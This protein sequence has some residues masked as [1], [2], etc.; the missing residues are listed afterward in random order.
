[1]HDGRFAD[2]ENPED[3]SAL[4]QVVAFYNN[5][6]EF[7]SNLDPRLKDTTGTAARRLNWS[8]E[9]IAAV[10]AYLRTQT[11]YV[12]LTSPLF[13]DPFVTLPG[14]YTGDGIVDDNDFNLST[15]EYGDV[16]SLQAD[17]NSDLVV[18]AADYVLWRKFVGLTWLDLAIPPNPGS[19]GGVPEPSGVAL[20]AILF[21]WRIA[22][23]RP[24]SSRY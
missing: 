16:T 5:G 19:S 7:S 6:V 13:A 4:E 24:R 22:D 20:A 3:P 12:F 9:N 21:G 23:R 14:D 1:M 15:A 18:D 17:G 8:E 2:S 10:V 11:D